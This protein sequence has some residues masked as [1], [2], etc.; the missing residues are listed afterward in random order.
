[1]IWGSGNKESLNEME[2]KHVNTW[3]VKHQLGVESILTEIE[4]AHLR[5]IGHVLRLPDDRLVS[6]KQG[7]D[8]RRHSAT[9]ANS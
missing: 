6:Q 7:E 3:D 4:I 2:E 9:G 8:N 1:M 5:R